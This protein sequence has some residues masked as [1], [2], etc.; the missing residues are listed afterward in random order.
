VGFFVVLLCFAVVPLLALYAESFLSESARVESALFFV[1][2]IT[3]PVSIPGVGTLGSGASE[4]AVSVDSEPA[5]V[6]VYELREEQAP[7]TMANGTAARIFQVAI[8]QTS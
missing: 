1:V 2:S 7:I 3:I 8:I 6:S 5:A 4:L